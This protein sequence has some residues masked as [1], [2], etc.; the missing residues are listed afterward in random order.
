[1]R[2]YT[3][4]WNICAQNSPCSR[5]QWSNLPCKTQSFETVDEKDSSNQSINQS[6]DHE[7]SSRLTNRNHAIVMLAQFYSLRKKIFTVFT[8]KT[9]QNHHSPALRNGSK[10][11]ER[12]RDK[13]PAHAINFQT[14]FGESQ[15]V[16]KTQVWYSSITESR[17]LRAVIVTWCCYTARHTLD[18]KQV[19]HLSAGQCPA[20]IM[21]RGAWSNQLSYP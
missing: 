21:A 19:L 14:S 20:H 18:L 10:Q 17:L 12:R 16:E 9:S 5:V 7:F 13:M 3:I 15:V 11:E 1:M 8:P 4:L 2:R 6:I